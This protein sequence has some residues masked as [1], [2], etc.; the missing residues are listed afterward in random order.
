MAPNSLIKKQRPSQRKV[1][2]YHSQCSS[3]PPALD[4]TSFPYRV[5][6]A[7]AVVPGSGHIPVLAVTSGQLMIYLQSPKLGRTGPRIPGCHDSHAAPGKACSQ[8]SGCVKG[9]TCALKGFL[10]FY[11]NAGAYLSTLAVA[12]QGG[13]GVGWG[14]LFSPAPIS[15]PSC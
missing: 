15:G 14:T 9:S 4:P 7:Q 8:S 3:I 1:P 12:W 11:K 10:H 5:P 13:A 6:G 2:N